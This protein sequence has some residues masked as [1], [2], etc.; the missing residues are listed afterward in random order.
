MISGLTVAKPGF[1]VDMEWPSLSGEWTQEITDPHS[2]IN[3][4]AG[5]INSMHKR[6]EKAGTLSGAGYWQEPARALRG[7]EALGTLLVMCRTRAAERC[8]NG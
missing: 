4:F 1:P 6:F 8:G 5:T 7:V 2:R 3:T